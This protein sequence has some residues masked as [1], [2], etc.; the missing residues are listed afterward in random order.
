MNPVGRPLVQYRVDDGV[1]TL[2]FD[3]PERMNPLSPALLRDALAALQ[4]VRGDRSVRVLVMAASGRGF[5][6]GADLGAMGRTLSQPPEPGAPSLGEQT[7]QLMAEG[8]NVFVQALRTLPVPVVC[9]MHGAVAG[10]GVG[11]VLAADIVVAARSAYF[12]LPFAPAL[13]LVP[14]MGCTWFM[15]RAVG[16][17]RSLGLTLL[18]DKLSAEQAERW[19]LIWTC[20]DDAAL[21]AEVGRIASRLA[22]LPA[23][24][25]AEA[26][27]LHDHAETAALPAQLDHER[28]RQR[29]LIDRAEFA[30]GVLAFL[31]RR[32]P[33]FAGR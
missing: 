6:S 27:A 4:Q 19:G 23:H 18:G 26:R 7:A 8:G 9:A 29:E 32:R 12:Y 5:C 11:V 10:G 24:A 33:A 14:D 1:A 30:E 31:E 28:E 16:R 2:T 15:Q 25:V 20:V 13:G 21:A 3:D 22:A 17:T